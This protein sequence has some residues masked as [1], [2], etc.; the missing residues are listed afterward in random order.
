MGYYENLYNSISNPLD[1]DDFLDYIVDCY[2]DGKTIY[3]S[4]TKYNLSQKQYHNG[5]YYPEK[6]DAFWVKMFNI[7]K[8]SVLSLTESQIRYAKQANP[9]YYNKIDELVYYLKNMPEIRTAQEFWAL[10]NDDNN[11]I[12]RY[13]FQ[14]LGQYSSWNHIDSAELSFYRHRRPPVEHRLYI[15]SESTDTED[16]ASLFTDKCMER[17]IPFYYKFDDFAN[18][19]DSLVIYSSSKY[20]KYYVEILR[21]LKKENP[22]LFSRVSSPP[23]MTGYIDGWIGYGS[24]PSSDEYGNARSFNGVREKAIENA[25]YKTTSEWIYR[26]VNKRV[27]QGNRE[28]TIGQILENRII[29]GIYNDYVERF[30]EYKERGNA[31]YYYDLYG[32]VEGDFTSGRFKELIRY[33]IHQN[34]NF[35]N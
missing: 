33:N 3:N 6:R 9:D 29:N 13:G 23:I 32:L 8:N 17:G 25:L 4:I 21:E 34:F 5:E 14:T 2:S 30:N 22:E 12:S 35:Y 10:A 18:R 1:N 19:D 28:I 11:L 20:L 15:N 16:I 27:H 7:W 26:N 31:N 24:E